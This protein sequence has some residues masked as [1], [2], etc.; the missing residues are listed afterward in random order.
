MVSKR[1]ARPEAKSHRLF[2]AIPIPDE[3]A[4]AVQ[5]AIEPWQTMLPE[6]R[7]IPRE[8]WHVTVWFL[9]PTHPRSVPWVRERFARVSATTAP[10]DTRISGVGAFPSLHRARV[11][12]VGIEDADEQMA[13]LAAAI[14]DSLASELAPVSRSFTPHVTLG[15]SDLP[16]VLPQAFGATPLESERFRVDS[17]VLIRSHLRRPVPLYERV[18]VYPMQGSS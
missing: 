16:M 3:A 5:A 15:R 2:V 12:W 1:S 7:W 11:L 4:R 18:E 6:V 17:I 10:L 9:G 14:Q 13:A 8:N